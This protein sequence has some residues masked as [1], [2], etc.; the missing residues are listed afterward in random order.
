MKQYKR[1]RINVIVVFASDIVTAST[2]PAGLDQEDW[3]IGLKGGEV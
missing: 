1:L 3:F 2:D